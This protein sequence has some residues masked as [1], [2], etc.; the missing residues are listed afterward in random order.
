M[1]KSKKKECCKAC[2][3]KAGR[4]SKCKS[5]VDSSQDRN[6]EKSIKIESL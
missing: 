4:S 6:S 3:A 1:E 5:N 2:L